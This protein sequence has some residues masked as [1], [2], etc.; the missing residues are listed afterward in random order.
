M[1]VWEIYN[2]KADFVANGLRYGIDPVVARIIRNRDILDDEIEAYLNGGLEGMHSAYLLKNA[3]KAAEYIMESIRAGKKI[4][5]IGDYDA[6]GICSSYILKKGFEKCG[7]NVDVAIPH[8]IENGYG[9]CEELIDEAHEDGVELIVT[10]DNG[11]SAISQI[12][13]ANKLGIVVVVTDHHELPYEEV[14]GVRKEILPP[15]YV[16]VDPKQGSETYPFVGICGAMVAYKVIEIL[17]DKYEMDSKMA[18]N[19]FLEI[20]ALATVA[21]IM[22]L[23]DENRIAVKYGLRKMISTNIIGLK[24]LIDENNIVDKVSAYHIGFVLGPC[25]NATGR[26]DSAMIAMD[27]LECND[28]E[29]AR[30]LAKQLKDINDS[31]KAMTSEGTEKVLNTINEGDYENDT[32]LVVYNPDCHESLAGIIAGR[33]KEVYHKPCFVFTNAKEGI[34]GSGRSIDAYNMFDELV[35]CKD[36]FSKFGGHKMA[37]GLSLP[38]DNLEGFRRRINENSKLVKEDL[39][40]KITIDVALPLSYVTD[41]FIEQLDKLEPFGNGNKKPIFAMKNVRFISQRIIGK[42]QNVLK[43]TIADENGKK[44]ELIYFGDIEEFTKFLE[45]NYGKSTADGLDIS[46]LYYPSI[47]EY[48]GDKTIQFVMTDYKSTTT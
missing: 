31:R 29:N 21:D 28:E 22:E 11:I 12:E 14:N 25:L 2:K 17:Y 35:K 43:A 23:R 48:M 4:R 41:T 36:L 13:Y 7:A 44:R 38:L 46:I 37:A 45:A 8:R 18:M 6:D 10:C 19:D 16:V 42:N 26:L 9:I 40:E 20:I 33:V 24:A 34:K 3:E 47:N 1:A 32:V 30:K 5:I 15:A 39:Q 27:L